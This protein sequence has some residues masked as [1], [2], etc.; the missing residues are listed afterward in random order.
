[1][2]LTVINLEQGM[3]TVEAA[4]ARLSQALRTAKATGRP[5]L[6]VIHGYGSSGK[7][8]SIRQAVHR[9]LESR[10]LRGQVRLVIP[11][12]E[13]SPFGDSARKAIDLY[14]DLRR[15]RDYARTNQGVTI[16]VV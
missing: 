15:D 9:D 16:V 11:G 12:E 2:V 13:F 3:P 1:M 6:K 5:V 14:P 10:R 4:M 7:G 8:G